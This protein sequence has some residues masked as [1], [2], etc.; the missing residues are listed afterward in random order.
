MAVVFLKS[1]KSV[2]CGLTVYLLRFHLSVY[3]A[4]CFERFMGFQSKMATVGSVVFE[5]EST[6]C[7]VLV[8]RVTSA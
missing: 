2:A 5:R 7:A 8:R 6:R 3:V 4:S 1:T